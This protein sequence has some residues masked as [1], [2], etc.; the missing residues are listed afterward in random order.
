[1]AD[2]DRTDAAALFTEEFTAQVIAETTKRSVAAQTF[3]TINM[4]KKISKMPVL[5]TLPTA[6]FLS[7]PTAVKPT[8]EVVW[9]GIQLEAE[10]IA[11]IVPIDDTVLADT[12]IDVA[13]Q[14]R[15]L[16]AQAFAVALDG[17]V[18]FGTGAPASF[19][20]N[21][22]FG[23]ADTNTIAYDSAAPI[24]T[25]SDLFSLVEDP[26]AEVTN[27]WAARS[28]KGILRKTRDN[29][30]PSADV[31]LQGVYGVAPSFGLGWVPATALAIVGDAN[32]AILGMRQD[33]TFSV[34]DQA[35]ITG[36]G[37]LWEKDSTAIRAVMRVGCVVADPVRLETGARFAPF[38]ALTPEV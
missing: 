31:N 1:M 7:A 35:T 37:N 20:T 26:G 5:D 30:L 10:E 19:P 18:F 13:T 4:G 32:M 17:A 21:G 33:L 29:G 36:Y 27:L 34:S 8:T 12:D 3:R 16:I 38:A 6:S 11:C 2:I 14:V 22:L 15:D 28:L 24:D 23:A 25:W 9:D